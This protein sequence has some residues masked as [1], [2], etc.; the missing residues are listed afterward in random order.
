[1]ERSRRNLII[2][3]V[4]L[5]FLIVLLAIQNR[6]GSEGGGSGQIAWLTEL[7]PA[8]ASAKETGKPIMIDFFATWCG[9]CKMLDKQTYSDDRVAAASTN[10]LMV[11][12][13]VDKNQTLAQYYSV[14]S[15]PTIVTLGSDGK[16]LQREVGFIGVGPML[17]LMEKS[18]ARNPGAA[19]AEKK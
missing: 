4:L 11:R 6:G 15:I 3:A 5:G 16:E 9:P 18:A 14:S 19:G 13:D 1:M 12:I 2:V 17:T 10:W 7:P 8:L